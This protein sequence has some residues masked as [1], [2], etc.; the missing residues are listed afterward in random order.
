MSDRQISIPPEEF[1]KTVRPGEHGCIF[2][3]RQEDL[4][5][6]QYAY[7]I[8]GL[9]QN[10]GVVYATPLKITMIHVRP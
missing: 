9:E 10:M 6:L 3:T 2:F 5:K 7:V 1:V 4:R 8:S